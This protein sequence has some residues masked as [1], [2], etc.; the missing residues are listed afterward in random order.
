MQTLRI[1]LVGDR[2]DEV[3][4]HRAIPLVLVMAAE[5]CGITLDAAW[6]GTDEIGGAGLRRFNGLWCAPASPYRSMDGALLAIRYARE[7]YVPFLGTCAGFQ[8]AVVEYARNVLGWSDADHAETSPHAARAVIV[9][10][11]CA[12]VEVRDTVRLLPGSRIAEAYGVSE[13]EEGYHCR[14][15]LGGG[16]RQAVQTAR[17]ASPPSTTRTICVPLN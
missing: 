17:C 1:G 6:I 5:A 9:P 14:Y 8:H 2:N 7:R 3:V 12:L 11:S 4:A 16:F 10:L 13:I 15:G